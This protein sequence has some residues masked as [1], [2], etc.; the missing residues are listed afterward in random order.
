[1]ASTNAIIPVAESIETDSDC[2]TCNKFGLVPHQTWSVGS[3]QNLN[4]FFHIRNPFTVDGQRHWIQKCLEL[5]PRKPS[6]TN[7]DLHSNG[8]LDGLVNGRDK[9]SWATLGYHHNWDTKKYD[10]ANYSH[11]PECLASL[12]KHIAS[13]LRFETFR[14]E[15]AI[16]NYYGKKSSLGI[17]NDCSEEA[18]DEPIISLSFGQTA[19]FLIGTSERNDKPK[20]IFLRSGDIVVMSG[21][22]RLSYHAVP[23]IITESVSDRYSAPHEDL[24]KD[25][26]QYIN[27]HR[28]N[29]S[30]RQVYN[31]IQHD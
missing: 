17:H 23:A 15:A 14:P 10:P 31:Q 29:M 19:I 28:I 13:C 11:F 27:T 12:T 2:V 21:K 30:V 6:I 9:L 7:M 1:M 16:V 5:Y 8:S 22:C 3:L 26:Y 4:G 25:F 24:D 20:P 18:L